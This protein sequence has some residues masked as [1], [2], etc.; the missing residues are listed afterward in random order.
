MHAAPA[1]PSL[2]LHVSDSFFAAAVALDNA[3]PARRA[4]LLTSAVLADADTIM[5]ASAGST[6]ST[7]GDNQRRSEDGTGG[8][9]SRITL[10]KHSV[11]NL[12][13]SMLKFCLTFLLN[14]HLVI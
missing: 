9:A 7:Q 1:D 6:L 11:R 10:Y 3:T 5:S 14:T 4:R 8:I 12:C 13:E 2:S